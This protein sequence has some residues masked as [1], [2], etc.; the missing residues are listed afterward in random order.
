[1]KNQVQKVKDKAQAIVDAINKDKVLAESKL[2][3]ARPALEE[4]EAALNTI[5]PAGGCYYFMFSSLCSKLS[6]R[7]CNS[8]SNNS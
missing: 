6:T 4:A 1:M 8:T 2:E 3:A 7:K 5:K